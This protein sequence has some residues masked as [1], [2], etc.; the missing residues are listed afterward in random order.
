MPAKLLN[1]PCPVQSLWC[2]GISR[3]VYPWPCAGSQQEL[4]VFLWITGYSITSTVTALSAEVQMMDGSSSWKR[5]ATL[6]SVYQLLAFAFFPTPFSSSL[7]SNL[8]QE[9]FLGYFL[10]VSPT[11]FSVLSNYS[12]WVKSVCPTAMTNDSF[13]LSVV[14]YTTK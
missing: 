10:L 12:Y 6:S 3:G 11:D 13:C 8:R 5:S 7:W 14:V 1:L 4:Q 2:L 9:M